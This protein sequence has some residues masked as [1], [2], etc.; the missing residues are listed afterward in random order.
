M[1]PNHGTKL[2]QWAGDRAR[3]QT[4]GMLGVTG[5]GVEG[6][7]TRSPGLRVG[8]N[9]QS[10]AEERVATG[11]GSTEQTAERPP[12]ETTLPQK[13][14]QGGVRRRGSR[15]QR[16]PT[17]DRFACFEFFGGI[18]LD[19]SFIYPLEAGLLAQLL[20]PLLP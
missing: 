17:E 9:K 15:G 11:L 6:G 12:G 5:E 13:R 2:T 1:H 16:P 7:R 3:V 19:R 18:H 14:L 20:P 4:G 10:P 8:S